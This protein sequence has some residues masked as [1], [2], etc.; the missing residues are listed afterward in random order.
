MYVGEGGGFLG[1]VGGLCVDCLALG[2]GGPVSTFGTC[3]LLFVACF[4][5][6]L[7]GCVHLPAFAR[8]PPPLGSFVCVFR[9]SCLVVVV[10]RVFF[11]LGAG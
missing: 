2:Q 4:I 9:R 7:W 1:G 6:S 10:G 11:A 8:H 5:F 3:A